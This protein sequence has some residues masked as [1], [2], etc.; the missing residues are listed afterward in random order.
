[1]N[2]LILP[3]NKDPMGTAIYDFFKYGKAARLRVF[4]SQF[5]EDEIPV[6]TLFRS[7]NEMPPIE[8][9]ALRLST[10]KILDV[11]AGS[12]CHT[13]ALR[14][15]GKDATAIDISPLSV[16]VMK[17]RGLNAMPVNL[18]DPLFCESFDTIL[19]LMNGSGIIGK[20]EHLGDFFQRMKLLLRHGGCVLMDSSDLKYLF[21]E[22]DGSYLIDLAGDYYG[23][24]D[25]RMQ[26]KQVKGDTFDWLYI[27]FDT[28]SLYAAQYG[29]KAEMVEEGSHY[30]YLA[31]LTLRN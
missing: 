16:K 18:F 23:E 13:L 29:F 4:S 9:T 17:E 28:L 19:M 12:G 15:M 8:Q 2:T 14:E 10:G 31:K 22:E 20:L 7:Y 25:F 26:Y 27:D 1:M 5:D 21:E 24:I 30:A 6:A 11:G 3:E